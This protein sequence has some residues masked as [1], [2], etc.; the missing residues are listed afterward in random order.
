MFTMVVRQDDASILAALKQAV[1]ALLWDGVQLRQITVTISNT[2]S[3]PAARRLLGTARRLGVTNIT[4]ATSPLVWAV[5]VQVAFER[6]SEARDAAERL[7]A[8]IP[9][10]ATATANLGY[11]VT[12]VDVPYTQTVFNAAP[13]TPPP[14]PPPP[15]KGIDALVAAVTKC[16]GAGQ[17]QVTRAPAPAAPGPRGAAAMLT[18]TSYVT[19][20][21]SF[22]ALRATVPYD[23]GEAAA[24]LCSDDIEVTGPMGNTT[25]IAQVK[26]KV[27]KDPIPALEVVVPLHQQSPNGP[28]MRKIRGKMGFVKF[29]LLQRYTVNEVRKGE[30]RL[31]RIDA[32]R[33]E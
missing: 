12:Q 29:T 30:L 27:F 33:I 7:Q 18:D 2:S 15:P 6:V 31:C 11:L 19:F 10:A 9:D 28:V 4:N 21:Q 32:E 17:S 3:F 1:R 23:H 5:S 8:A 20:V 14:L 22:L 26:A 16:M 25:G 24:L 13:F